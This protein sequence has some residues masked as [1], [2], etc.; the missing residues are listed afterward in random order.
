[1]PTATTRPRSNTTASIGWR[2]DDL[3]RHTPGTETFT[4][5]DAADN[6]LTRKTRGDECITFAYDSP[7]SPHEQDRLRP[8]LLEQSATPGRL[9]SASDTSAA[10]LEVVT[11][12]KATMT[13]ANEAP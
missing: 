12:A 5:Y 11:L 8:G 1:M 9:K 10:I 6:V 2:S 4:T 7:Q 13:C 3:R